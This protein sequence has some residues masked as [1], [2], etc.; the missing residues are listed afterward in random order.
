MYDWDLSDM[1]PPFYIATSE[2]RRYDLFCREMGR[3]P[4]GDAMT[5]VTAQKGMYGA[6]VGTLIV[7]P[8][9]SP[10]VTAILEARCQAR[11]MDVVKL[12]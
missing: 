4:V 11:D 8:D 12:R 5:C 10:Y 1:E 2:Y 6:T 3:K 7:L 9:F